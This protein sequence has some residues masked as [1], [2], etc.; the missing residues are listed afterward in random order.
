[1]K[2]TGMKGICDENGWSYPGNA[3]A[4][5]RVVVPEGLLGLTRGPAV[6]GVTEVVVPSPSGLNRMSEAQP[7]EHYRVLV[8]F[9]ERPPD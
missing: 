8:P 5:A 6:P 2:L 9:L 4:H 7:V 1:M 3:T